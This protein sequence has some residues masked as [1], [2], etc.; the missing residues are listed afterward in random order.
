MTRKLLL[1]F[2]TDQQCT[3]AGCCM[4]E[5]PSRYEDMNMKH[6]TP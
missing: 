2:Y 4:K 3:K 1:G 5:R 6:D